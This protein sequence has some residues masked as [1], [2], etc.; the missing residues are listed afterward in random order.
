MRPVL[1]LALL[2]I[3]ALPALA[4]P[5]A[6][7]FR[8]DGFPNDA[9]LAGSFS[10]ED[11]NGDGWLTSIPYGQDFGI[12]ATV[13]LTGFR[14]EYHGG[15]PA[16]AGGRA[17]GI[18]QSHHF[19]SF[20][21][22]DLS[23]L[24]LT[25][26]VTGFPDAWFSHDRVMYTLPDTDFDDNTVSPRADDRTNQSPQVWL[27]HDASPQLLRSATL[28]TATVETVHESANTLLLLAL[29]LAVLTATRRL[30]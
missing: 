2:L 11:V 28:Q 30:A 27:T 20:A 4:T 15:A 5:I 23:S 16:A 6:Y 29:G 21:L 12:P 1:A 24:A 26:A 18:L 25:F 19:W 9:Y 13:E 10:G 3:A 14:A 17:T 22:L 7:E 8:I